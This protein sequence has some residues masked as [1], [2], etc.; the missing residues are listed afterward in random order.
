MTAST[1][2]RVRIVLLTGP[3]GCGK[4]EIAT[5]LGLPV[6][7]LDDFYYDDTHPDLPRA[8]GIIDWDDVGTW[9]LPGAIH[10]L[11]ELADTG[12]AEVPIYHIPTNSRTGYSV[13]DVNQ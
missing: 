13:L 10:A 3:S 9:D 4:T 5:R 6:V 11:V 8:H 2:P 1:T 12:R 7:T